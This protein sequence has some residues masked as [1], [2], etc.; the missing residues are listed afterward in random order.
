MGNRAKTFLEVIGRVFL[1]HDR[2]GLG[3]AMKL[4]NSLLST[5]PQLQFR[6]RRRAV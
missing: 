2:P 6:F 5:N 3:Q 4:L 1:V